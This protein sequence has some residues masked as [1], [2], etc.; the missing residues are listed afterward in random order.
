M[1]SSWVWR[2]LRLEG[3]WETEVNPHHGSSM[4]P[5]KQIRK[6]VHEKSNL[7]SEEQMCLRGGDNAEG[8]IILARPVCAGVD[9]RAERMRPGSAGLADRMNH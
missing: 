6:L 1:E 3:Y 9:S 2:S 4:K 8:E 7:C 5:T